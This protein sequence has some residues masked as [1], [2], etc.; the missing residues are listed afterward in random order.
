MK[1]Y[2][3]PSQSLHRGEI[4]G[5]IWLWEPSA[6]AGRPWS[7][8]FVQTGIGILVIDV[9]LA[10]VLHRASPSVHYPPPARAVSSRY[11]GH[12]W[13]RQTPLHRTNPLTENISSPGCQRSFPTLPG[14]GQ[15]VDGPAAASARGSVFGLLEGYAPLEEHNPPTSEEDTNG[16]S[17]RKARLI[18]LTSDQT[19]QF[20]VH[21]DQLRFF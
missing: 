7:A 14:G 11:P 10:S 15:W 3:K 2:G 21:L 8:L 18:I 19:M 4:W 12:V 17:G 9:P 5:A 20:S 1:T 16:C 13:W 6:S